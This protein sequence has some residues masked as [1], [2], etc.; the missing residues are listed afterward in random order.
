MLA[1]KQLKLIHFILFQATVLVVSCTIIY[2]TCDFK[3]LTAF[4]AGSSIMFLGNLILLS[5]FF[6][7]NRNFNPGHE[8][9]MLYLS[10][11]LKMVIIIAGTILVALYLQP[12][13][14]IYIGGLFLLQVAIWLM[15]LF[16]R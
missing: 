2:F 16:L 10:S 9:A 14:M 6:I 8:L 12:S 1:S 11:A 7:K 3:A 5:R 4:F 13:F 15:P